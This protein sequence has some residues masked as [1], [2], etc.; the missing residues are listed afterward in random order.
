[1]ALASHGRFLELSLDEPLSLEV[2]NDGIIGR[3]VSL[4]TGS[5]LGRDKVIAE[6]IVGFN[7]LQKPVL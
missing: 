5:S 6:G 4:F 7:F 3:R 1:V 2:G